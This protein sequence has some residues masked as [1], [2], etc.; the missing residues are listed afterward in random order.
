M[1]KILVTG[2]NGFVGKA[3]CAELIARGLR[4]AAAVRNAAATS[5][6]DMHPLVE[7]VEV[8]N[9]DCRTDWAHA[10]TGCSGVIHLAAR[11]HVLNDTTIDPLAAFRETNVAGTVQLARCA[12]RAGVKRFVFV[13]SVGVNGNSNTRPF[14]ESDVPSPVEPYAVSKLEA[15]QI[16]AEEAGANGMELVIVRPPLVYGPECPGNFRRLL[17]LL[18]SGMPLPFAAIQ[19]KRSFV[20]V[21][22][23]ADF[24][25]TC[26]VD[27]RAHGDIFL[28]SDMEDVTLPDLLRGLASGMGT[29]APLFSLSPV[30][31]RTLANVAGNS[32]LFEKLC[33][34]L[35]V[36]ANHARMALGWKPPV[37]LEEGLRRTGKWY[38]GR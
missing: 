30:L 5:M 10:L 7:L 12:A 18:G 34:S 1:E 6:P 35:T 8:G 25:A 31:L 9:I 37:S 22:N 3:V 15:E 23:L 11:A 32:A 16:L 2:A 14:V 13:S 27:E 26:V 21:W 17:K 33:G 19:G 24:L 29:R 20:S 28:V 38:A 4:V 36:D